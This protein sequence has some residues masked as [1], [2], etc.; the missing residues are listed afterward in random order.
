[1]TRYL[2][3]SLHKLTH[4]SSRKMRELL[5]R[6]ENTRHLLGM[7]ELLKQVT[8][9]CDAC[10][11][12]NAT[13]LKLPMGTRARGHWPGVHWEID[14]TEIKP[15]KYGYKYLLVFVDTFLGWTEAYPT[16]HETAK[17]VTKKLL[18]EIFPR[19]GMPQLT[20]RHSSWSS[21]KS[22]SPWPKPTETRGDT[23][24][25]PTPITWETVFGS[26]ATRL[27]TLNPAG[28]DHTRSC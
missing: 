2:I 1:M 3:N 7:E 13:R 9:R 17:V 15:G 18:E 8:E 5:A 24:S 12:V 20:C 23:L 10:A 16:K 4:L 11:R 19:Y 21:R 26:D 27:R 6:E 14:F 28:R 25:S 22:G